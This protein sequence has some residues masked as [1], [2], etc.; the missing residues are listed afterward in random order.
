MLP[1]QALSQQADVRHKFVWLLP[2]KKQ[3]H[4]TSAAVPVIW[5]QAILTLVLSPL[6]QLLRLSLQTTLQ[7]RQQRLAA[8]LQ[9]G[10]QQSR[11]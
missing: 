8:F 6:C 1:Q 2:P 9:C 5:S 10:L 11:H 3:V 4:C 7:L